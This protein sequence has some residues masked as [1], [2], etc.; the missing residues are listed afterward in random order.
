M[1]YD[2]TGSMMKGWLPIYDTMHGIRGEV[3]VLVKVEL[4]SDLNKFRQSSCGVPFF[5]SKT[6]FIV[7]YYN[8]LFKSMLCDE[9]RSR[10]S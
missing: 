9:I 1:I 10:S 4:F 3:H 5:C 7:V 2:E 8:S 6:L